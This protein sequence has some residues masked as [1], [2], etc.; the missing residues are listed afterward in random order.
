MC[1]LDH[2]GIRLVLEQRVRAWCGRGDTAIRVTPVIDLVDHLAVNQYE[3]PD[4]LQAF[5]AQRDQ[6]CV[7]PHCNRQAS[8]CDIDHIRPYADGG[9]T[10]TDNLAALCRRHHRLKTHRDWSYQRA[11]PRSYLW[12]APDGRH[13]LRDNH[14]TVALS[15]PPH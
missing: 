3:V 12:T 5:V 10:D 1:R 4:R 7:F 9:E 11:G 8:G 6:A 15:P 14:G 13:Y 2:H